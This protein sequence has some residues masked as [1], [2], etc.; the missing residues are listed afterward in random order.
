MP[1]HQSR[2]PEAILLATE[3]VG[4]AALV[5]CL[6]LQEL[7]SRSLD[8]TCFAILYTSDLSQIVMK[9]ARTAQ[10]P[11]YSIDPL[12]EN[13]QNQTQFTI[14]QPVHYVLLN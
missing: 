5:I 1:N 2:L 14:V 13:P 4:T 12:I 10:E 11:L 6:H 8:S 3:A 9:Q 7:P